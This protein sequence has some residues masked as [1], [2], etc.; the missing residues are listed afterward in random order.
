MKADYEGLVKKA[1]EQLANGVMQTPD[2]S[3]FRGIGYAILAFAAVLK[4]I[5]DKHYSA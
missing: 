1:E 4:E 2:A 5:R 3:A